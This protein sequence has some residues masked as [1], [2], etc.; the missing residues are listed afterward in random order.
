MKTLVLILVIFISL[1]TKAEDIESYKKANYQ[2][3][4]TDS[5]LDCFSGS[6]Y[7]LCSVKSN[8]TV[9]SDFK[10]KE[11]F[12]VWVAC[13]NHYST[14][15]RRDSRTFLSEEGEDLVFIINSNQG[16]QEIT[17]SIFVPYGAVKILLEKIECRVN[18]FYDG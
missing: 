2:V 3:Y 16:S 6:D 17:M 11:F 5:W 14:F 18:G 12:S 10:G 15:D 1:T 9:V 4:V 13:E 8:V 7:L